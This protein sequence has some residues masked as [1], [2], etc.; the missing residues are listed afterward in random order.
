MRTP[1][2]EWTD[3]Q[4]AEFDAWFPGGRRVAV[5]VIADPRFPDVLVRLG[6]LDSAA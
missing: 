5:E 1:A 3:E 2:G 4:R 6:M